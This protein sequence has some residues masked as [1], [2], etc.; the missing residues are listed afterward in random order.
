[1]YAR[2][3]LFAGFLAAAGLPI[4]IH[5][6]KFYADNYGVSLAGIATALVVLRLLDVVQDPLLGRLAGHL[7]RYR[8][9]AAIIAGM[10]MIAGM[11]GLFAITPPLAP[12]LWMSLCLVALFS[13]YSFLTI[14]FYARGV[15]VAG[16]GGANG[17]VRLA[18]WREFGALAGI[19]LASIAPFVFQVAGFVPYT[20]YALA[21][22]ALALGA[23]VAMHPLWSDAPDTPAPGYFALLSDPQIRKLLLI[24]FFN[25][26]PVAV[27]STLFL[28]FVDYRLGMGSSAGLFLLLFFVAAAVAAPLWAGLTRHWGVRNTLSAAM[29]L[30]IAAFAGAFMLSDGQAVAFA[31]ICVASGAALGADMTLLPALFSSHIAA[32]RADG[33]MAFGLWNFAAKLTLAIAAATVLP[34]LGQAGFSTTEPNSDTALMR[35]SVLYALVPCLLKLIALGLLWSTSSQRGQP[36]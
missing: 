25:A 19:S 29:A 34:A 7:G 33:A 26:A 1:M 21:F 3:S 23:L 32:S 22:G 6:P 30:S 24:G 9:T 13:G 31:I 17:H 4:Y 36:C 35:L 11:I 8:A 27:T 20:A 14:L 5:A 18:S 28:F 12:L 2:F 10:I 15:A 16:S